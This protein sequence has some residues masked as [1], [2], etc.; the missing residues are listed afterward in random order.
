MAV[1]VIGTENTWGSTVHTQIPKSVH[2]LCTDSTLCWRPCVQMPMAVHDFFC[3]WTFVIEFTNFLINVLSAIQ[4][5][6]PGRRWSKELFWQQMLIIPNIIKFAQAVPNKNV[7]IHNNIVI[8]EM[9]FRWKKMG[10]I[11]STSWTY[12]YFG[13]SQ[14]TDQKPFRKEFASRLLEIKNYY[15]TTLL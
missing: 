7:N 5:I 3:M 14:S 4:K 13:Y 1:L 9:P 11:L 6:T 8:G 10:A 2:D 12:S 15:A